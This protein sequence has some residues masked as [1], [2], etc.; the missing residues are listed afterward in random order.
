LIIYNISFVFV[1]LFNIFPIYTP[2]VTLLML[3]SLSKRREKQL[4][5]KKDGGGFGDEERNGDGASLDDGRRGARG[6]G[7]SIGN[8]I[9]RVQS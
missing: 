7:V 4:C 3:L 5:G 9:R 8:W 6:G 1:L 2:Q